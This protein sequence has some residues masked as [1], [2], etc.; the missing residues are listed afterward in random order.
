MPLEY[1]SKYPKAWLVIDIRLFCRLGVFFLA[2]TENQGKGIDCNG[3]S[4]PLFSIPSFSQ[5]S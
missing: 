5:N 2:Q 1:K 4:L 3:S